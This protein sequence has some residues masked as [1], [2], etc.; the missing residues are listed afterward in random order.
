LSETPKSEDKPVYTIRSLKTIFVDYRCIKD[1]KAAADALSVLGKKDNIQVFVAKDQEK[2]IEAFLKVNKVNVARIVPLETNAFNSLRMGYLINHIENSSYALWLV[3][4]GEQFPLAYDQQGISASITTTLEKHLKSSDTYR[5]LVQEGPDADIM[6]G[7]IFKFFVVKTE[8][9]WKKVL[10]MHEGDKR[11]VSVD[12]KAKAIVKVGEEAKRLTEEDDSELNN[13]NLQQ[14]MKKS[15]DIFE[16]E[17][18]DETKEEKPPG[19]KPPAE[20]PVG[21]KKK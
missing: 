14:T 2:T 1:W 20:K 9:D 12:A 16:E 13:S 7:T 11:E 5:Q 10:A 4:S 3:D 8:D 18:E 19:A 6:D 21:K 15:D 17:G